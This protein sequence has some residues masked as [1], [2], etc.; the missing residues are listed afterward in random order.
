MSYHHG[1]LGWVP[2]EWLQPQPG[3]QSDELACLNKANASEQVRAI[4]A[5][6]TNLARNWK[7]TGYFRP[8]D[9]QS[10]ITMFSDLA[11]D[12][13]AALAAAPLSTRDAESM[14]R[15]AFEDVARKF[16]DQSQA[17]KRAISEAKAKGSNVINAPGLKEWVLRSMRSI[18]DAYV[19]ATVLHCRQTWIV[20]WLDRAHRGMAAIGEVVWRIGGVAAN[21]AINVVDAAGTAFDLAGKVIKYAPYAAAGIGAYMLYTF[22]RKRAAR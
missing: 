14:K 10:L 21:L 1:S 12:A 19:T 3:Q 8:A 15:E 16:V 6:V 7:P 17:Y 4:D 13:G 2:A 22:I 9:V 20:K 18:S 11:A 5:I